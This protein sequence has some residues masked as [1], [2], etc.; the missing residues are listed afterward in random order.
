MRRIRW[1]KYVQGLVVAFAFSTGGARAAGPI[2][3]SEQWYQQRAD[4]PPGARQVSKYGKLWP[5]YPRPVGR[6]ETYAHAFHTAHYWP[7]P[8]NCQDRADVYNLL[9]S[10]ANAGW[11]VATTLHDYHFD[12]D[13][14]QLNDAGRSHALW[15]ANSVPA[16]FRT[17]YVAQ[18]T[19]P[20]TGQLRVAQSDK[21][22]REM[23]TTNMPP[24]VT[25][26]EVFNGRPA[27]EVDRIRNLELQ[28]IPRPRLFLI[29][30]AG[31]QSGGG[32]SGGGAGGGASAS[33]G[34]TGSTTTQPQR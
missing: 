13:T 31:R 5:P 19:T 34:G 16:Q 24:I 17:L 28:S 10:Q 6:A 9:D 1:Q 3:Y 7:H 25:K 27:N 2:P 15:V 22:L 23:G 12:A 20:E 30:V 11:V 4:D 8:Y 26:Y 14:Q 32:G 18:G 21:Y 29:G 33:G